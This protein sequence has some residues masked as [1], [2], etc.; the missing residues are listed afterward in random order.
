MKA[1]KMVHVISIERATATISPA[2]T[3]V[4]TWAPV[5]T[6]RAELVEQQA[7]E[8]LRNA[9]DTT[10]ATIVFRTRFLPSLTDEDRVSFDGNAFDID[11]IVPIGRRKGLEIR[12]REISP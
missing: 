4:T 6:L 9:G 7:E 12:C 8:F 3:P 10:V 1:G 11:R 2:G 5:A